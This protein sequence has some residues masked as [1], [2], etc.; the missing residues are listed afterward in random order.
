MVASDAVR[1]WLDECCVLE[2]DAWT[3][4]RALYLAYG[5][6]ATNDGSKVLSAR[7][8]YNRMEQV[9]GIHPAIRR[10]VRGFAGLCLAGRDGEGAPGSAEQARAAGDPDA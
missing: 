5:N 1:A 6:H 8:F 4:R 3:P 2:L 10:G 7:E 9:N